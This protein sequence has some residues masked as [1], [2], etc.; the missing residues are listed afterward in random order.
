MVFGPRCGGSWGGTSLLIFA[1]LHAGM[2]CLLTPKQ[3]MPALRI[4]GMICFM[5]KVFGEGECLPSGLLVGG[6]G[7]VEKLTELRSVFQAKVFQVGK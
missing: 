3:R 4:P 2:V 7:G 6:T 1:T 5:F